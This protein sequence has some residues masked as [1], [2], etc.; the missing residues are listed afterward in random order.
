MLLPI[1][2]C[3][4]QK[5]PKKTQ[6]HTQDTQAEYENWISSYHRSDEKKRPEQNKKL[7]QWKF[8][9]IIRQ[10][11]WTREQYYKLY[12]ASA[13]AFILNENVF[14]WIFL[15][16]Q[17]LFH[18]LRK[19]VNVSKLILHLMLLLNLNFRC[20]AHFMCMFFIKWWIEAAAISFSKW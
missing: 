17:F 4:Y 6:S 8:G 20:F 3:F 5:P 12:A 14:I 11:Q 10:K 1:L 7:S 19:I 13:L 18:L 9:R 2:G 15:C 16:F